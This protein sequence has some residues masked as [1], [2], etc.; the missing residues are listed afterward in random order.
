MATMLSTFIK[1]IEKS[2]G[3]SASIIKAADEKST[4]LLSAL[5]QHS[6][7]DSG[8]FQ[9]GWALD[10]KKG[11]KGTLVSISITNK[12]NLPYAVFM[13]TGADPQSAPWYYPH[14]K[15]IPTG[16]L[17]MQGGKVWAG[18]L[19]PGHGKT[20]GGTVTNALKAVDYKDG[21]KRMITQKFVGLYL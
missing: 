18:G 21:L 8:A 5:Q 12:A 19:N 11:S 17:T 10:T 1:R 13:L 6:P 16:K 2:K 3:V 14:E 7:V 20:V 4:E 15:T 9:R